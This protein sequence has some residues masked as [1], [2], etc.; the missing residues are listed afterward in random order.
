M[1]V[2]HLLFGIFLLLLLVSCDNSKREVVDP[3]VTPT[4]V[5]GVLPTIVREVVTP[6]PLMATATVNA[7][8]PTAVPT[9]TKIVPVA[10][11]LE[12]ATDVPS[13]GFSGLRFALADD[14]AAQSTFPAGTDEIFALWEYEGMSPSDNIRRIWF[15]DGQIWLTREEGWN[16]GKYGSEG[17]M[18]DIS[19]YDDEGSGLASA[20]YRLQLYVND[21]LHEEGTFV[22]LA[23]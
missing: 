23:P 20:M 5:H 16:W 8:V 13:S 9:T 2:K 21:E 15:R 3:A 7:V 22:V 6:L 14:G 19:V 17:T 11:R 1:Y 4:T 18:R 12:E 10:T